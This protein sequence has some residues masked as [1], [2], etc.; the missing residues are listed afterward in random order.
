VKGGYIHA[1]VPRIVTRLSGSRITSRRNGG[2]WFRGFKFPGRAGALRGIPSQRET[3]HI[4]V[5]KHDF[6]FS[7]KSHAKRSGKQRQMVA[8]RGEEETSLI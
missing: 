6:R 8:S 2:V 1:F 7:Q 3:E 5:I 4:K